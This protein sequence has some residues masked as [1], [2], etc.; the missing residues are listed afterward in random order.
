MST[1]S[2]LINRYNTGPLLRAW[3]RLRPVHVLAP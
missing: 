1:A 3:H 2:I